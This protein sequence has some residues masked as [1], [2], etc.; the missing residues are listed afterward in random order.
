METDRWRM[1]HP[2]PPRVAAGWKFE[3]V[4]P[5]SLLFG[6]NGMTFGPDGRLHVGQVHGSQVT[7]IDVDSVRAELFAPMGAGI[8]TP[9]DCIFM[10]DGTLFATS[11]VFNKVT[12]RDANGSYRTVYEDLPSVNGITTDRSGNRL[13]VDEF[14]R[15]GR[16][17][18][19]DASGRRPAE[20]LLDNLD[21]PNGFAMGPDGRLYFPLVWG[22]QVWAYDLESRRA[23]MVADD[24]GMPCAVKVDS[25]GALVVAET[26]AGL[27]TRIDLE[28]GKRTT[29]AEVPKGIDNI[30][31]TSDDR[32]FVSHYIN[33]RVAEETGGRSR[34][35]SPPGL[36]GPRGLT[37]GADGSVV[38]TDVSQ[39]VLA[40]PEG[41][42][43]RFRPGGHAGAA[44]IG[45]DIMILDRAG[46]GG[47][48]QLLVYREGRAQAL[49]SG[50]AGP[51]SLS[52]D[53]ERLLV[54]DGDAG[55]V[56][57][58]GLDGERETV[59]TG[60]RSP[61]A[62][63]RDDEGTLYVSAGG[64]EV[65]AIGA[66]R[67]TRRVGGFG[68]AQGLAANQ[69]GLLVAD[70]LRRELVLLSL[71]TLERHV[72]VEGAPIGAPRPGGL[73]DPFCPVCPDGQNGFYVG[74]NGDGSIRRLTPA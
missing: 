62:V 16:L 24:L 36:I 19:L 72:L 66:N 28:T 27:V 5:P 2:E 17:L 61:L 42:L 40:T 32:L 73:L 23:E 30:S 68:E 14:R 4:V 70:S 63:C 39:A 45:G 64:E 31:L 22:K 9:D 43:R 58:V 46:E 33:G 48:A 20:V 25:T 26:A 74:C 1:Y 67:A 35:I 15:G 10:A 49:A 29:L 56:I 7:A 21:G 11:P 44:Q 34:L 54:T 55:S 60:L 38:V 52:V 6:A 50:F 65:L 12:A 59:A 18:E 3:I 13:F 71:D 47:E 69:A 51:T 8:V 53:G 37:A 41:E 57:A